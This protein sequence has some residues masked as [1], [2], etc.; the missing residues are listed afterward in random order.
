M[1]APKSIDVIEG[2]FGEKGEDG[3]ISC[4]SWL[5]FPKYLA[6]IN[7]TWRSLHCKGLRLLRWVIYFV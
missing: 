7:Y 3:L 4:L 5:I 2:Q 1:P 6:K